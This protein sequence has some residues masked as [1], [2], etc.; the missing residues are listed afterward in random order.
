MGCQPDRGDSRVR[1]ADGALLAAAIAIG[2]APGVGMHNVGAGIAIGIGVAGVL[3][4]V[5][6]AKQQR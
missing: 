4:A 2:V 5:R 1:A 3:V 6:R